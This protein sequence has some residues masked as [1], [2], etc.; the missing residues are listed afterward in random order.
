MF[1][2]DV[3]AGGDVV[4]LCCDT[5]AVAAFPH[6][7]LDHVAHAELSADL[8]HM[9]GLALIGKGRVARD[10]EEPSQLGQR[11]DDV[12]ADAVGEILLLRIA[13][14]VGEWKHRDGGTIRQRQ[15]RAPLLV[16]VVRRRARG[17][18][19]L[20]AVLL[21]AHR[22]D[23]AQPLARD[24]ADQ[25]LAFATVADRFAGGIDAAAQG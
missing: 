15:R 11:R 6:A 19:R 16:D 20:G 1:R 14:H 13:A 17:R 5:N 4:E 21:R 9:D 3:A 18:R 10:H 2:P 25:P 12:L 24:C 22:A 23:E 7:A 8:L